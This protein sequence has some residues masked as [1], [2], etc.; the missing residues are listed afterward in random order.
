MDSTRRIR[1]RDRTAA[2]AGWALAA[3]L[4][5]APLGATDFASGA[6]GTTGSE[7]LNIDVDPRGIAM[8][9]ALTSVT[10]DSYALYW[11][12]AGLSQIPRVSAAG[13]HNEYLAGIRMQ[14]FS[15]AQRISE[16]SVVGGAVRYMDAGAI[17]NTDIN[18]VEIGTFRPRNYVYEVGWGKSI[19]EMTD[20][21]RDI[22]LGVS[23]R[24]IHSDLVAR[25]NGWAGD[26]GIQAHYTES[27]IPHSFGLVIQNV[28]QGQQFDKV[29][30][31]LPLR[32]KVGSS[33]SPKPFL[34]LSLDGIVPLSNQPY[35]ALGVELSME[36]ATNAKAYLRG[37]FNT[38]TMFNGPEGLR[39]LS[40]GVGLKLTDFR[41]DY[42]FLPYGFLGNTHRFGVSWELPA[43]RSRRFRR[44]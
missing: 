23:G 19:A 40:V 6:I 34:L 33:V 28:G 21:E 41:F 2:L 20:S 13:M 36:A 29:R 17:S 24:L 26:A 3:L 37:G 43:K 25:A 39:G 7:F 1:R 5:A 4:C 35:A 31:N 9:G 42:A 12:P 14:Y 44:R 32:I 16:A 15:Y 8:G 11:N 10:A 38:L 27:Y 22:S 30:D 18:G